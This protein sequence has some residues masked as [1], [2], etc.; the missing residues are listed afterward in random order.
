M[1][2]TP[3]KLWSLS[4]ERQLLQ[5]SHYICFRQ[6][7]LVDSKHRFRVLEYGIREKVTVMQSSGRE[8]LL[9]KAAVGGR[10]PGKE[11]AVKS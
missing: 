5:S 1:L 7:A 11:P 8:G 9:L 6:C 4:R 3:S 2:W 10:R